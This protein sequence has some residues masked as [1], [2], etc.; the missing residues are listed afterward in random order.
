MKKIITLLLFLTTFAA[1]AQNRIENFNKAELFKNDGEIYFALPGAANL[2]EILTNIISIDKISGDTVYAYASKKEYDRLVNSGS[3]FFASLPHP[4]DL[5]DPAMSS[6]PRDILTWNYYPTY[7][8]Y[9][10]IMAQFESAYPDL[11]KIYTIATLSSGRKIQLARIS[12]NVGVEEDEPEFLYTS[13]IHGDETTGYILMLHLIDYLLTNYDLDPRITEMVNGIDLWINP[14][15]N[16]DGTYYGGDNTVNGARRY[17]A[18]N[19]DLNRNYYDPADGPHPDGNPWQPETVAFMNF[20]EERSFVMSANFHGGAEVMN[21]PW[22]TWSR[23][24]TDDDWWIFVSR[25]YAD[26]V[27]AHA[28]SGYLN[29]LNNGITNG[30]AWYSINGGRQDY[31]NYFHQCREITAEISSTKLPPATQMLNFWEYNYRSLLNYVEQV[32]YGVRGVVTD[33]LTGEPVKA[34]VSIFGYD[35]VMDSSMVFTSLPVGN[36]HRLLK[37]GSYN[38][39]FSAEGYESK[40]IQNVMISDKSTVRLDVELYNGFPAAAFTSSQTTVPVGA[41]VQFFD[42][43]LGN[44]VSRTWTF[45]GGS[46]STS[47]VPEPFVTYSEPGS[48]DVSLFVQ[49]EMGSNE[50]NMPDYITVTPDY[51]IGVD[52]SN[53]CFA[54][55]YDSQGPDMD[56]DRNENL[57]TTFIGTDEDKVYRVHFTSFDVEPSEDCSKDALYVYDGPDDTW[58]LIGKYCGNTLPDDILTSIGGGAITFVF[59]SDETNN[60]PGWSAELTC[61]SGVEVLTSEMPVILKVYPNPSS[62]NGFYVESSETILNLEV[63]DLMGKTVYQNLPIANNTKV[64]AL[65]GKAG[66][67]ALKVTTEK[68]VVMHKIVV[69]GR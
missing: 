10:D 27:H 30:Y 57:T 59:V 55:L 58:P 18:N 35:Q 22:D 49:N 29:D 65:N 60:Y 68:G 9:L 42:T 61:D 62:G 47:S 51:Y 21:Y 15:A 39:T 24:N 43:S 4:G 53:T 7:Q 28:A 40:T 48:W 45:E 44:P 12:D 16:P 54:R 6:N 69:S 41:T 3:H 26:T 64:N 46:I 36:Y 5:I 33:S 11:C 37:A 14:L 13:S 50:L 8:G 66:I 34:M 56:Y 25:E 52:G 32:T 23:L 20:A 67:Y 17:N 63:I 1:F 38:I 31:M 2:A 19:V